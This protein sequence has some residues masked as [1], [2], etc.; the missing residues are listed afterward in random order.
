GG[1]VMIGISAEDRLHVAEAVKKA[2]ANSDGEIVTIVA[3]RSDAYHDVG[4]HYAVLAMLLV[5][6]ALA[7]VP[8]GWIDY[9]SGLLLGWNGELTRGTVMLFLFVKLIGAFL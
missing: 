2:E 4:L 6:A 3:P 8:Q 1:M 5:P 9:W 7:F